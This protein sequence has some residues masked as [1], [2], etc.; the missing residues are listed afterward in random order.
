MLYTDNTIGET[1]LSDDFG[2]KIQYNGQNII[3]DKY[4]DL[5][6]VIPNPDA[7]DPTKVSDYNEE[8]LSERISISKKR[9]TDHDRRTQGDI[10]RGTGNRK[11][12]A[13]QLSRCAPELV[14]SAE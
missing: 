5:W 1:M 6:E 13:G 9:G 8:H 11:S 7:P 4:I 10:F 3:V 12:D 2:K 14:A